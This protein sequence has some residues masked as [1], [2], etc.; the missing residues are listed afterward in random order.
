MS[1]KPKPLTIMT[2]DDLL[3]VPSI[4]WD[5]DPGPFNSFVVL[6]TTDLHDSGYLK[7][8]FVLCR[9]MQP[10]ARVVGGTDSVDLE[11]DGWIGRCRPHLDVL[12]GSGLVHVLSPVRGY[13]WRCGPALSS[14]SVQLVP[15]DC[16]GREDR[17]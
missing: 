8:E 16:P 4:P 14:W 17:P 3:A 9:W 11:L 5:S 12:P 1:A 15:G 13:H 10:I 7:M 6:P 2:R